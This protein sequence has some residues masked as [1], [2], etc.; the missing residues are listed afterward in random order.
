MSKEDINFD[1]SLMLDQIYP[2][3]ESILFRPFVEQN[4]LFNNTIFVLDTNA[5]LAPFNLG[6]D[7]LSEIKSVYSKL[8]KDKR[9]FIPSQCIKEFAKNRPEK[10]KSL[11]GQV[12]NLISSMP[13]IDTF[14]CPLLE[15]IGAYV[16][17]GEIKT[18]FSSLLKEYKNSL[19]ELKNVIASWNWNDPVSQIYSEI[20]NK[21]IIISHNLKQDALFKDCASRFDNDLPPGYKDKNKQY[22]NIGDI[23]IWHSI[24]ELAIEKKSNA[25]FF[26]NDEKP[27]W[28]VRDNKIPIATRFE[29]INEFYRK[30]EGK[31]FRCI[32]FSKFMELNGAKEAIIT[33]IKARENEQLSSPKTSIVKNIN[34][35]SSTI[36]G[37]I[38]HVIGEFLDGIDAEQIFIEDDSLEELIIEF[39]SSWHHEFFN[40]SKWDIV[41]PYLNPMES[42]LKKIQELNFFIAYEEQRMKRDT[43]VEIIELK[44][45]AREF[46]N[47]Y[48]KFISI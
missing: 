35:L 16:K 45:L 18:S 42:I 22:N 9:L 46:Y 41:F 26:T 43:T 23:I 29:L 19:N 1:K 34:T 30:T 15:G 13:K 14:S 40:T 21:E 10:I 39:C 24:V 38:A 25:V 44:A 8:I 6:K 47:I 7:S 17:M 4:D 33:E 36:L 37:A 2:D 32:S 48:N 27:D 28:M 20:F 11:H 5:L 3:V 31:E 12:Y